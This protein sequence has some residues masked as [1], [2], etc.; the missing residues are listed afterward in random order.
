MAS[1]TSKITL[2]ETLVKAM[3]MIVDVLPRNMNK[4]AQ[5]PVEFKG[6]L[7]QE[8]A[9]TF[10]ALLV[11]REH[12]LANEKND[13][14]SYDHPCNACRR[15]V[16][17]THSKEAESRG[18]IVKVPRGKDVTIN[19]RIQRKTWVTYYRPGEITMAQDLSQVADKVLAML[20]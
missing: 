8:V 5:P 13:T 17:E 10:Y 14:C 20:G 12:P 15:C 18:L 16:L 19:G 1:K 11:K 9:A 7:Q 6:V 2:D 4:K 3:G